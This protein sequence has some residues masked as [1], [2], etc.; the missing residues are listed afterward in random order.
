[1]SRHL[2]CT[3]CN[4]RRTIDA[5][6]HGTKTPCPG[7][8]CCVWIEDDGDAAASGVSAEPVPVREETEKEKFIREFCNSA[9]TWRCPFGNLD[10]AHASLWESVN[11]MSRV[12]EVDD[13]RRQHSS[14]RSSCLAVA[15]AAYQMALTLDR[16]G[17]GGVGSEKHGTPGP[18]P[19][20]Q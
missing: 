19:R 13:D 9:R 16:H 1:M 17:V 15:L 3:I 10:L 4:N 7:C 18:S 20:D 8:I 6:D 14:I 5:P 2:K 11:H 12:M